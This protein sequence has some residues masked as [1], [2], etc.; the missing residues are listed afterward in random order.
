MA[1]VM[2]GWKMMKQVNQ[3]QSKNKRK[4]LRRQRGKNLQK[5]PLEKTFN[6]KEPTL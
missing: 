5:M 1:T 4:K 3:I 2:S 6:A